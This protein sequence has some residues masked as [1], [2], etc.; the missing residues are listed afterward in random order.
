[1]VA[2][3]NDEFG[4]GVCVSENVLSPMTS[5]PTDSSS[6]VDDGF[7][8]MYFNTPV[9]RIRLSGRPGSIPVELETKTHDVEVLRF[10]GAQYKLEIL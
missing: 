5:V 1:M 10:R 8:G 7:P 6:I 4:F 9:C 2:D 3:S